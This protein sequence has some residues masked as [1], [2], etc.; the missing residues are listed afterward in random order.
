MAQRQF[1]SGDTSTWVDKYGSGADGAES[2]NNSTDAPI[3]SACS[4]TSGTTSLTATNASFATGQLILIHQSQG[5]GVGNWEL[6]KVSSYSAGTITTSYALINTYGTGAQ[7][8]VM[9]QRS[10]IT[11]NTGQ[12]LTG[13]AWNGTVGGIIARICNGTTTITGTI[14]V[15]GGSAPNDS[16]GIGSGGGYRGGAGTHTNGGGQAGSGEGTVGASSGQYTPNGNGGGGGNITQ[17]GGSRAATGGGGGHAATGTGGSGNDNPGQGG[18]TVGNAGLT[19]MNF[20]GGG[21]GSDADD[22][23]SSW[24]GMSGGNGGG[25]FLVIS[26]TITVTGSITNNGGNGGSR[27]TGSGCGGAGAAGGSILF[28]GQTITLGTNLATATQGSGGSGPQQT[29]PIGSVGRI[30]ADYLTSISGTTN[31]TIGSTQDNTLSTSTTKDNSSKPNVKTTYY[32]GCNYDW[33]SSTEV[34]QNR[35]FNS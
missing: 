26:K 28:K 34:G 12:T 8:L 10:A 7:V 2:I 15:N 27:T 22:S 6:N 5:T 4:G 33:S 35:G 23:N 11:V 25:I 18:N 19:V 20:G 3:D 16:T 24:V 31:P 9:L 13:K 14:T 30:H 21:G 29:G 1:A 32:S 17:G